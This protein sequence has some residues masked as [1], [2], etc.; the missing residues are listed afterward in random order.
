MR[1]RRVSI[2]KLVIAT[3][4]SRRT[5]ITRNKQAETEGD[6]L[7][8]SSEQNAAHCDSATPSA[9]LLIVDCYSSSIDVEIFRGKAVRCGKAA[10]PP[11]KALAKIAKG[12][13]L[14]LAEFFKTVG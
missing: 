10:R 14:T 5:L 9:L 3:G 2:R 7:Q 13:T 11:L 6:R 4:L 8:G 1:D 12:F